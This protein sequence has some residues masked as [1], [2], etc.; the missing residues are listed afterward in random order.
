[1]GKEGRFFEGGLGE[2]EGAWW[3]LKEQ[4]VLIK[5]QNSLSFSETQINSTSPLLF[6][7]S[8]Y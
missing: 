4:L 7:Q 2:K 3:D 1:M 6:I 5:D 8:H